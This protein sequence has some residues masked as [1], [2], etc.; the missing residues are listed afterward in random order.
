MHMAN[1][2]HTARYETIIERFVAWATDR[3]EII[4]AMIVGSRAR[5]DHPADAW[6]DLDVVAF[7]TDPETMLDD[8]D[9]LH[10]I[11][12]PLI[13]YLEP[14]AVGS[15]RE[16]RVLFDTGCDVDFSVIPADMV[17]QLATASDGDPV[18][19]QVAP[20][21]R[22]GYRVLLDRDGTLGPALTRIAAMPEPLPAPLTQGAL[23]AVLNDFWYHAVWLA[24]KLRRGEVFVAHECLEGNQRHLLMRIIRWLAGDDG[25]AW[26][27][28]RFMEEWMPET[29]RGRISATWAA[30]DPGDIARALGEMMDLV[31]ATSAEIARARGL[32]IDPG[33]EDA[34]RSWV[35]HAIGERENPR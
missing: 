27:G 23:D 30:H 2:D 28:T 14:T 10:H 19:E 11:G 17:G 6:S 13:T 8:A 34:A 4:A 31:S 12:E 7:S 22:R 21:I 33:V 35:H 26:H 16:R 18:M 3:P 9:W 1:A 20:V 5:T 25:A 29:V 15:W 32:S 24:R